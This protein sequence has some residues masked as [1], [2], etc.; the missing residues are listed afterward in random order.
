MAGSLL[1]VHLFLLLHLEAV[2]LHYGAELIPGLAGYVHLEMTAV[3]YKPSDHRK[4]F[5]NVILRRVSYS[6]QDVPYIFVV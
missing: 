6:E 5:V 4:H 2:L 3:Y 1:R